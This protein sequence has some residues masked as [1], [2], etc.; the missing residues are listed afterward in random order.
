MSVVKATG[1]CKHRRGVP[2]RLSP[3]LLESQLRH[4]SDEGLVDR[5]LLPALLQQRGQLLP[6]LLILV[7]QICSTRS[8]VNVA[9]DITTVLLQ[10]D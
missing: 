5:L 2:T 3:L 7:I 8:T 6:Q 4:L 9:V 10:T 1:D